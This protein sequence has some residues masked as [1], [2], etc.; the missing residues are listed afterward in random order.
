M[1]AHDT[2]VRVLHQLWKDPEF[3][4][5]MRTRNDY[6]QRQQVH[7]AGKEKRIS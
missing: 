5:A 3:S 6:R 7:M 1:S 2:G 4:E